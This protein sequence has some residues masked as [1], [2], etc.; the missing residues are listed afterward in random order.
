LLLPGLISLHTGN[1]LAGVGKKLVY[2]LEKGKETV[3]LKNLLNARLARI[4]S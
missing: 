1:T 2:E 3:R 4:Y